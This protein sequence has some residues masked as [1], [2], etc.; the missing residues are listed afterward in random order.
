LFLTFE[1]D[2]TEIG[3]AQITRTAKEI[4]FL[5]R[6]ATDETVRGDLADRGH[7]NDEPL[8]GRGGIAAYQ[9]DA[10]SFTGGINALIELVEGFH[11]ESVADTDAHRQLGR[12]GIHRV[13]IAQI[14]DDGFIA[15][16]HATPTQLTVS[17][18]I[19]NRFSVEALDEFYE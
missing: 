8:F 14:H 18:G 1:K 2:Q 12:G 3:R 17:I 16:M 19:S 10:I 6:V 15:E 4:A 13:D 7:G 11:A 9:V 5:R